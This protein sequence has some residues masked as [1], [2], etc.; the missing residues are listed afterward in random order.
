MI[1]LL[2]L[3]AALIA[4][5]FGLVA[6]GGSDDDDD[7]GGSS[8]PGTSATAQNDGPTSSSSPA[9]GGS[10]SGTQEVSVRAGERGDQYFFEVSNTSL[11]TGKVKVTL[12]N[13]GPERPH[14]FVV[15][16]LD[17]SGNLAELKQVDPNTSGTLEFDLTS[18]GTYQ[19]QCDLRGHADRGQ[20]GSFTVTS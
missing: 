11:K 18:A 3:P 2:V 15:K 5:S 6:C 7:D 12:N 14:T 1:K 4:L 16:K 13:A 17:G 8:S 9:S 10:S 19:F 20:K